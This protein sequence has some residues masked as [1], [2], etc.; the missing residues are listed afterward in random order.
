[1]LR[2][3]CSTRMPWFMYLWKQ[4][5]WSTSCCKFPVLWVVIMHLRWE[6]SA[7]ASDLKCDFFFVI[8]E[9][10]VHELHSLAHSCSWQTRKCN[11]LRC[12]FLEILVAVVRRLVMTLEQLTDAYRLS[13]NTRTLI[14]DDNFL[15]YFGHLFYAV[16][17]FLTS[18]YWRWC[19]QPN[20]DWTLWWEPSKSH[21]H[22][23]WRA[24]RWR[25]RCQGL[26][27]FI[28]KTAFHNSLICTGR[29]HRLPQPTAAS[30]F[31]RSAL[32][33]S[34]DPF[35]TLFAIIGLF[36]PAA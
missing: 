18:G 16:K 15:D 19:S 5:H 36:S 2:S 7:A 29:N 31:H 34:A 28:W 32:T 24:R 14:S 30:P 27:F 25:H 20:T 17:W 3:I 33:F 9:K 26:S 12:S 35:S 1:M 11:P 10:E 13:P 23:L 8:D 4:S 6:H 21:D 22:R